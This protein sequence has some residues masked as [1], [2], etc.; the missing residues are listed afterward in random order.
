MESSGGF[1]R[2]LLVYDTVFYSTLKYGNIL[3]LLFRS[4]V[5]W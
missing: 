1:W 5:R 4:W 3:R 2:L